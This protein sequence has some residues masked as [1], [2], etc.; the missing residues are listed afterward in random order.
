MCKTKAGMYILLTW[1]STCRTFEWGNML[2]RWAG[3]V[4][5]SRVWWWHLW[6]WPKGRAKWTAA[7]VVLWRQFSEDI[8]QYGYELFKIQ[9]TC[10]H[11]SWFQKKRKILS[12]AATIRY[13]LFNYDYTDR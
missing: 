4:P 1:L 11:S 9:A 6:E 5:K 10:T 12:I 2:H 7:G 3:W 13:S 8:I